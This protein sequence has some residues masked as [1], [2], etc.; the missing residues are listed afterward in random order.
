MLVSPLVLCM[1]PYFF[2]GKLS[3]IV[4]QTPCIPMRIDGVEYVVPSK[5][6]GSVG[7]AF[8]EDSQAGWFAVEFVF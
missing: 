1:R 4:E 7:Y 5:A 6:L 2:C 3:V 8:H